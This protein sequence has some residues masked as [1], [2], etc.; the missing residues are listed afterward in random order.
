MK[1]LYYEELTI[2]VEGDDSEIILNW[3]GR[4]RGFELRPVL[5]F[6]DWV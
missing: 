4:S 5:L 6:E 2:E 1:E 3:F